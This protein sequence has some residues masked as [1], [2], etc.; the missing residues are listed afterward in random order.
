M[1]RDVVSWETKM[2]HDIATDF[3]LL[4]HYISSVWDQIW[5]DTIGK[6]QRG[7][8]AVVKWFHSL[9]SSVQSVLS[10]LG[11]ML[12]GIA[13]GALGLFLSGLEQAAGPIIG[14]VQHLAS[15]ISGILGSIGGAISSVGSGI[16]GITSRVIPHARG[17][18]I[19][20]PIIGRGLH[21][22]A[23]HTFGEN[24]I[25]EKV[26]PLGAG[27]AGGGGGGD[28]YYIYPPESATNPDAYA[29]TVIQAVR[30]Y[31]M[32]HGNAIVGIA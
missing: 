11:K 2:R 22:G 3:D 5:S 29:L 7:V 10:G 28:T 15:I 14:F 23:I 24:G 18:I 1:Y 13:S 19:A 12:F 32:R 17:G 31:K 25:R 16:S 26:T 20:E 8:A 6:V 9:P 21:T 4:R 27:G 30:K